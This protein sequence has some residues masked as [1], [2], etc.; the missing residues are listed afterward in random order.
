MRTRVLFA[1]LFAATCLTC[2]AG[3]PNL[4]GGCS[5]GR[6]C[7]FYDH[8]YFSTYYCGGT[9]IGYSWRDQTHCGIQ[10]GAASGWGCDASSC[11]CSVDH[12]TG[13]WLP[14]T[15]ANGGEVRS[16]ECFLSGSGMN[17]ETV[18]CVCQ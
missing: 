7:G 13:N 2:D 5:S 3:N 17:G 12:G 6:V 9:G 1:L 11:D 10:C 18:V 15:A 14:C 4:G 8:K 16:G